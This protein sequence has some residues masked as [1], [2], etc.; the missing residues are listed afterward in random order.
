MQIHTLDGA[1]TAPLGHYSN[2]NEEVELR[3]KGT[4][5]IAGLAP[6]DALTHTSTPLYDNPTLVLPGN[7]NG[8]YL[9]VFATDINE[10]SDPT[11]SITVSAIERESIL[12]TSDIN[13]PIEE[14]IIHDTTGRVC[15]HQTNIN[16]SSQLISMA[17]GTYIVTVR[18]ADT[19]Y[20]AKVLV[21]S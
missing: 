21:R 13:D 15:H 2:S 5:H 1:T 16:T 8:R 10:E 19:L 6:Y 20:T 11:Q 18:T 12:V 9:L 3:L 4:V 17:A 7:T 14:V